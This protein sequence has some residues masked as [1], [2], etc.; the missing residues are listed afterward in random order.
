MP[1]GYSL[2]VS[3][4]STNEKHLEQEHSQS[5]YLCQVQIL[6]LDSDLDYIQNLMANLSCQKTFYN[7]ILM[8]I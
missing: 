4:K 1:P 7:L 5:A 8:K 6:S 2:H 3:F